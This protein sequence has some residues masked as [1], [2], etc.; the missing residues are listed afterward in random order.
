MEAFIE[1]QNKA[2]TK[3]LDEHQISQTNCDSNNDSNEYTNMAT[4]HASKQKVSQTT[5]TITKKNNN[6]RLFFVHFLSVFNYKQTKHTWI[7]KH[8]GSQVAK[9]K[10]AEP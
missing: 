5:A 6:M 7:A 3:I 4:P 8:S 9:A 2:K 10:V 1:R